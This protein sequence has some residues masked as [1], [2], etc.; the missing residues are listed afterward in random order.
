MSFLFCSHLVK[1]NPDSTLDEE[2]RREAKQIADE[3]KGV[4]DEDEEEQNS[5]LHRLR[6]H[7]TT[8]AEIAHDSDCIQ[9]M[10]YFLVRPIFISSL[11]RICLAASS[12]QG[13]QENLPL[14]NDLLPRDREVD[15]I[16]DSDVDEIEEEERRPRYAD[17]FIRCVVRIF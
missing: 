9:H 16:E 5:L 12:F 8:L 13:E 3:E 17:R 6:N 4:E 15:E 10:Y 1:E 11:V 14:I 7:G 2:E